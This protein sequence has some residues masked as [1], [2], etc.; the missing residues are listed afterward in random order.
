MPTNRVSV[1]IVNYN[2]GALVERCVLAV[3]ASDYPA[4]DHV[5][6]SDNGSTDESLAAIRALAKADSRVQVIQ[7]GAN[8]GFAAANN[9]ALPLS[10]GEYILFLNPDCVVEPGT[11]SRMAAITDLSPE[12]GMAGCLILN[13]DGSEQRGCRR[14]LPTPISALVSVLKLDRLSRGRAPGFDLTGT[15]LPPKAVE[16]EAISGAFMFVRRRA[17]DAVG[18][19]DEGYFL[20]CEDLDWCMR[21]R[22]AAWKI[23]FLPDARATHAQGTSSHTAPV[24]VEFHKHRGMLRYYGKFL[25]DRNPLVLLWLVTLAV[26]L[27]FIVKA[28]LIRLGTLR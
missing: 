17:L 7:N 21:F 26:W 11:I 14:N 12:T 10:T 25:R 28:A 19:M 6:V 9:R 24:A 20:H 15:P 23:M 2:G 18:P 8:I 3:L 5:I 16:V 1:V 13:P 27:R 22:Q 4:I